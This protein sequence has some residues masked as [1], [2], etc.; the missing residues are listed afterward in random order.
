M[1]KDCSHKVVIMVVAFISIVLSK[2][3]QSFRILYGLYY[4]L[5]VFNRNLRA[6]AVSINTIFYCK[7][8][9]LS[10]LEVVNYEHL[11]IGNIYFIFVRQI[12]A[13]QNIVF[14]DEILSSN[15]HRNA[16]S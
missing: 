3:I 15:P 4:Y 13:P 5:L 16:I 14:S 12:H 7:A 2:D 8:I 6:F 1:P 9:I 11:F 10:A